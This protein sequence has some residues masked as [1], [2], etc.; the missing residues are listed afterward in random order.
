MK[1]NPLSTA[2]VLVGY[3][4]VSQLYPHVPSLSM[5]RAWEYA[6]YRRFRLPEPVLDV[7]C[8]DGKYFRLIWPQVKQVTGLDMNPE[9][10]AAAQQ[11]GVYTE[12]HVAP[13]HQLPFS[14]ER[15]ASAFANCSLEHMDHL[16]EVLDNIFRS[17]SPGGIF[18][19]SVV[20]EKFIEWASLPLLMNH[21]GQPDLSR[22][23]Q[24]EYEAF[25]HL[26]SPFPPKVWI[27]HLEEAGFEVLEHIP[28]MPEVTSRL[29]LFLDHVW[30]IKK[31]G[32]EV[33]DQLYPYLTTLS[34]FPQ[35]CRQ[36]L[37]GILQM[38]HDW[39]IGSGAVFSARRKK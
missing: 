34:N 35:A 22:S 11:S 25:H 8:G 2:E 6:A 23:L 27:E 15:F 14:S 3:D 33:G 30:H 17:L 39:S 5:W 29:F 37:H 31:A 20:T 9:V 7:G 24:L 13:A 28:I 19:S 1:Q 12:T 4:A 21:M 32:G 38:E 26:M 36:V 16:S 10:V 18:L